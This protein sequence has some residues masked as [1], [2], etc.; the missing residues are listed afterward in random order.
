MAKTIDQIKKE[1][2]KKKAHAQVRHT[3]TPM[4]TCSL[5][6]DIAE[7]TVL[8]GAFAITTL[9]MT[10]EVINEHIVKQKTFLIALNTCTHLVSH[11]WSDANPT[12][13]DLDPITI[14]DFMESDLNYQTK[15]LSANLRC[16]NKVYTI[17]A[18]WF[19]QKE[20]A[21]DPSSP[22]GYIGICRKYRQ[23]DPDGSVKYWK[24]GKTGFMS[25]DVNAY[26]DVINDIL[27]DLDSENYGVREFASLIMDQYPETK[28]EIYQSLK[29]KPQT[30]GIIDMMNVLAD[31]NIETEMCEVIVEGC[32]CYATAPMQSYVNLA[33][34][35]IKEGCYPIIYFDGETSIVVA[36]AKTMD[37]VIAFWNLAAKTMRMKA[38]ECT[39]YPLSERVFE[40][41]DLKDNIVGYRFADHLTSDKNELT[42]EESNM[43]E[44]IRATSFDN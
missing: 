25:V 19:P 43:S 17:E 42:K 44:L 5:D 6:M 41:R 37:E 40:I 30:A 4:P 10:D 23:E 22:A 32:E 38:L 29:T 2:E 20:N 18:E 8:G 13:F 33:V 31:H 28:A 24:Y 3:P 15:I 26:N 1:V 16:K 14:A 7:D 35:Y 21:V 9:E 36:V 27:I 34:T 11:T 12:D 39:C